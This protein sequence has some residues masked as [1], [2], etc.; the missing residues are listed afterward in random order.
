MSFP[1]S[2]HGSEHSFGEPKGM[3]T[4]H[5]VTVAPKKS[6][7]KNTMADYANLMHEK[8]G[9]SGKSMKSKG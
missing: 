9:E 8:R 4:E 7:G 6:E 1:G 3:A 2:K 5:E